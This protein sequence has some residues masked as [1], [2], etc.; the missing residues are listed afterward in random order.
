MTVETVRAADGTPIALERR[1]AGPTLV[2]VGG[3]LNDRASAG[4]LAERLAARFTALTY[5]RRGRGDSGDTPPYAVEREIEDLDAVVAAGGGSAFA[6][7][8]SSGAALTLRAVIAGT[9]LTR[10]A[11]YEPPFIVDDTRDPLPEDYVEHLDD[12]IAAGARGDA[13]A[14][15]LETIGMPPEMVAGMRQ[16][17]MWPGL[18][19][20][21]HTIAY[22][23]RV[24]GSD[25]SGRPFAEDTWASVLIPTL[26]LDGGESPAWQR[27]GARALA[28]ALPNAEYRTLAGQTH[29][30][31]DD[32]LVPELERFFAG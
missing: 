30:V 6:V 23:G 4:E 5:D 20:L 8:H 29:Q 28:D 10:I 31:S 18:E 1:G 3:A 22:D 7:G 13:V 32:V 19:A 25:M 17:P 27:N 21:A 12:L 9:P 16:A 14:Y 26:V 2:I 11:L 15:F 24:M